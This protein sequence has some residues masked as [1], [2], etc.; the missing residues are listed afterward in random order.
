MNKE[1]RRDSEIISFDG[2]EGTKIKQYFDSKNTKNL[3]NFSLAQF[4][5]AKGKKNKLH[6]LAAAEIY[7]I[8]KGECKIRINDKSFDLKKDDSIFIEPDSIQQ[9]ENIGSGQLKFLCIVE[10]E[11]KPE[12]ETLLE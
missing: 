4:S 8:L 7:Y 2:N 6:K 1:V 11:W 9:I 3:V 5:L 10:P 12:K